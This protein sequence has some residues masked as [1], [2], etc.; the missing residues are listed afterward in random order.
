[1]KADHR[2]RL[3]MHK[4]AYLWENTRMSFTHKANPTGWKQGK[5]CLEK[6]PSF[7][8]HEGAVPPPYWGQPWAEPSNLP[9]H[10]SSNFIYVP[11]GFLVSH[12]CDNCGGRSEMLLDIRTPALRESPELRDMAD[13]MVH[14]VNARWVP[15][16]SNCVHSPRVH[17][18]PGV[19]QAFVDALEGA[20]RRAVA[21]QLDLPHLT[22]I[23]D[24]G[25]RAFCYPILDDPADAVTYCSRIRTTI[26][27][28]K[29][30]V[31]AVVVIGRAD[32]DIR[33]FEVPCR[34]D[35]RGLKIVYATSSFGQFGVA[36]I[37]YPHG[38][39]GHGPKS[40]APLHWS[41]L[42]HANALVDTILA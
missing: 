23:L 8:M 26:R 18:T 39:K 30:D 42:G 14:T 32:A 2:V 34:D 15:D 20:A 24:A 11:E 13:A 9:T 28:K 36:A 27:R 29:L 12:L 1:M 33:D 35:G 17:C 37:E 41:D 21:R 6:L 38:S 7:L 31:L 25:G 3:G 5:F 10:I 40:V 16:H 22:C 4:H 19:V